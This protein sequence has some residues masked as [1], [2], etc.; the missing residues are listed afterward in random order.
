M[1]DLIDVRDPDIMRLNR[2]HKKKEIQLTFWRMK[3]KEL[4][5]N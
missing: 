5:P 2:R 3:S 4:D 1:E